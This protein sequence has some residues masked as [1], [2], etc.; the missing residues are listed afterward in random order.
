MSESIP[1]TP[2]TYS[3]P[4]LEVRGL[5]LRH[6]ARILHDIGFSVAPGEVLAVV[7]P[8]GCG[9]STLLL[10]LA[11]FEECSGEITIDGRPVNDEPL[12][13]VGASLAASIRQTLL[14]E[15]RRLGIAALYVTHDVEEACLVADRLLLMDAG[16]ILQVGA[17]GTFTSGPAR[18]GSPASW[19]SR[20]S[21]P[22]RSKGSRRRGRPS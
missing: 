4:L 6:G 13:H 8:S 3:E 12:A 19:A 2:G 11:G 9:K 7:G 17:P 18:R 5:R 10:A 14:R 16:R 1:E 22:A 15:I 21:S 20:T